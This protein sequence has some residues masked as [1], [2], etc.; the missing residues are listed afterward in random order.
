[1]ITRMWRGWAPA[2]RAQD[3]ERHYRSDVLAVLRGVAGFQG[4]RLLGRTTGDETEFVSLTFFDDLYA[5]RAFAGADYETAVV[6]DEAR[7]VLIRFDDHVGH[8]ETA[9]ETS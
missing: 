2:D 6:A 3:Y 5:V 7:E 4:A 9:F 8:Y 1:M